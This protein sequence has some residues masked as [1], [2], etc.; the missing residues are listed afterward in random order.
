MIDVILLTLSTLLLLV[1]LILC[2]KTVKRFRGRFLLITIG[3]GA[4]AGIIGS[5]VLN[6]S[7]KVVLSVVVAIL[8]VY[9]LAVLLLAGGQ[10]PPDPQC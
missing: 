7:G 2:V 4:V 8:F 6:M 5:L 1:S 9:I 3:I 10:K